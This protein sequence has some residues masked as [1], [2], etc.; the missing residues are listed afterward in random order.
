MCQFGLIEQGTMKAI[1]VL[2]LAVLVICTV[3]FTTDDECERH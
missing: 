1:V 2:E 3:A